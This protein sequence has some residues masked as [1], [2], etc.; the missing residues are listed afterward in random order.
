MALI[1]EDGSG[2]A[3][4]NSYVDPAGAAAQSWL[5]SRLNASVWTTASAPD[6][7]KAVRMATAS[8]D[9]TW[10]FKGRPTTDTQA[11]S[12]PRY[13][14]WVDGRYLPDD[15][16]PKNLVTATLEMALAL[17]TSD[18]TSDTGNGAQQLK[19]LNLGEG[20]IELEFSGPNPATSVLP[21]TP[22][23]VKN[24]LRGLGSLNDSGGGGMVNLIRG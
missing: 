5:D 2:L 22:P 16:L 9:S 6:R 14:A 20:A 23:S 19:S 15:A 4:A 13:G 7:E 18:R 8:L 3:D 17:L 11:L 24:L 21:W 10:E 1:V 12:W